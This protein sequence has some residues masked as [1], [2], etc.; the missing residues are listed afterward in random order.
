MIACED[1]RRTRALL[2]HAGIAAGGRLRSVPAH[3]E[4]ARTVG[5]VAL[6]LDGA[7][8]AFVTDA[9]MPGISDPG[10][11]LVRACVEAGAAGRGGARTRTPSPPRWCC[12]GCPPT[13]SCSR[14][15]CPGRGGPR[16]ERIAR[17]RGGAADGGALRI[18]APG[19]R[20][21]PRPR[22]RVRSGPAG[23]PR[24]RAHEAARG[25]ATG[26]ARVGA[27]RARRRRAA[28][29]VRDRGRRAWSPTPR[30]RPTRRST[31]R[32]RRSSRP[33]RRPGTR[34]TR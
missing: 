19:P 3:D 32:W 26:L 13:G 8:V 4:A 12:R 34:P 28:R 7:R 24:A 6:V 10:A 25:G 9:G 21:A 23:R 18:A 15:S 14:G 1:T 20:D 29:G 16:A 31:R 2:T 22:G 27:R 17:D 5:I 33:G 11:Q 30:R